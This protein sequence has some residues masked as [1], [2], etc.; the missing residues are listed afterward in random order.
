MVQYSSPQLTA[1]LARAQN[2][3]EA[4]EEFGRRPAFVPREEDHHR[5]GRE[6]FSDYKE[7]SWRP[8]LT[9]GEDFRRRQE[10][11]GRGIKAGTSCGIAG[12]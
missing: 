3:Q 1:L 10:I 7:D 12:K 11:I 5:S 4:R 2:Q 6:M 9:R 8:P